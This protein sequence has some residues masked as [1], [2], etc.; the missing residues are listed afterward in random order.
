MTTKLRVRGAA[1]GELREEAEAIIMQARVKMGWISEADL[2]AAVDQ[3][4]AES[5]AAS[6][7]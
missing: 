3:S 7:S 5:A 6:A 1:S 2:A 4:G